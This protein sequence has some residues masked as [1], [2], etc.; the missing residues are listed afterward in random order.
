MAT[1]AKVEARAHDLAMRIFVELVARNTEINQDS[2]K[3]TASAA[4]LATLSLR[5][6]DAFLQ[7]EDE[8]IAQKE[9]R[10]AHALQGE[11]LAQWMK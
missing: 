10:K 6:S 8:A 3:L 2:V 7:A 9:P 11:D 4:N 5:L 1:D